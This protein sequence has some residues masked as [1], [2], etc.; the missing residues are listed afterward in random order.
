MMNNALISLSLL[1]KY[2][3]GK[4]ET[5]L[6]LS[7]G[8]VCHEPFQGSILLVNFSVWVMCVCV[9]LVFFFFSLK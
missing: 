4:E 6:I 2:V 8:F 7:L 1:T 9:V 3:M 5:K